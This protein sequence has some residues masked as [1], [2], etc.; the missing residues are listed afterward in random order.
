MKAIEKQ[1]NE[2]KKSKIKKTANKK[3]WKGNKNQWKIVAERCNLWWRWNAFK[4]IWKLYWERKY[5]IKQ[6]VKYEK[7]IN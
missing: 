3:I 6:F 5:I 1:E 2:I 7:M 4:L